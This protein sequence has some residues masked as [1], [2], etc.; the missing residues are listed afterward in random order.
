MLVIS[1]IITS[2][3]GQLCEIESPSNPPLLVSLYRVNIT[4]TNKVNINTA[5]VL[6]IKSMKREVTVK[7]IAAAKFVL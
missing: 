1:L 2:A 4:T 7:K 5:S 3:K 6:N